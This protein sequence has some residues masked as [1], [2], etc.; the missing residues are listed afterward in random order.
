[1]ITPIL[2]GALADKYG[3]ESCDSAHALVVALCV[4]KPQQRC[5]C[6]EQQRQCAGKIVMAWGIVWFSLSSMLLPAAFSAKVRRLSRLLAG[7]RLFYRGPELRGPC[8]SSITMLRVQVA[9][10]GLTL[11]AVLAARAMV[12]LG[13]GV[14]LPRYVCHT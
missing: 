6:A 12:G 1:M 2:G 9:A 14:A 10:A 7:R 11:P 3:G 8:N 13:E 4:H 5:R